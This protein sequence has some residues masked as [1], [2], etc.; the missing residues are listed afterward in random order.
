M[1]VIVIG[2]DTP[3]GDAI[4]DVL[5][6]TAAEVR[7][8]VTDPAAVDGLRARGAK[9]ATG[10]VSDASHV[11]A[12]ALRCFCAVVVAEAASDGRDR[13]FATEPAAVQQGWLGA[14]R[15]SGLTRII[16][17]DDPSH[18]VDPEA[19][20]AAAPE[21]VALAPGSDLAQRVATLENAATLDA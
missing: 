1:P 17:V 14:I 16:W 2:A 20:A 13:A 3:A 21:T 7:A 15:N 6:G 5:A 11:E 4:V 19:L 12:A 8:F 18:P 9:V 10:D